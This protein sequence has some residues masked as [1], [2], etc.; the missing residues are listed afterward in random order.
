MSVDCLRF[1]LQENRR[2]QHLP[3]YE[4]LLQLA[5][6][7]GIPGGTVLRAIAGY[8]RHGVLHEQ[9]FFELA[10]ELPLVV[11]FIASPAQ[12]AD[13]LAAVGQA[14]VPLFWTRW[15]VQSGST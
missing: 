10:G 8:G 4:W 6:A 13:L 3:L 9:H 12:C 11:E 5:Q 14:G 15:S 2:Q 1:Y 7:Q